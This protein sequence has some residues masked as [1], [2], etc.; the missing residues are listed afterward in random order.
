MIQL[1]SAFLYSSMRGHSTKPH[2]IVLVRV[3]EDKSFEH[4]AMCF[5]DRKRYKSSLKFQRADIALVCE[6]ITLPPVVACLRVSELKHAKQFPFLS[7]NHSLSCHRFQ[8][9]L[10]RALSTERRYPSPVTVTSYPHE[11]GLVESW[12][13]YI[14]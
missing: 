2:P 4:I 12:D 13:I 10:C 9:S 7:Q 3:C 5:R 11:Q 14:P 6:N 1:K 8:K